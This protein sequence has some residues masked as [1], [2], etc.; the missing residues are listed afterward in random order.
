MMVL[1][2]E[3]TVN[4]QVATA[5]LLAEK[6]L[7]PWLPQDEFR[8]P[9]EEMLVKGENPLVFPYTERRMKVVGDGRPD[10]L[11]IDIDVA[12]LLPI[13]QTLQEAGWGYLAAVTGVDLGAE[14]GE[15][16][17]LYHFC[18]GAAVLALCVKVAR[19]TAVVPSICGIIPSASFFERELREMLGVEITDTPNT[20]KLFLPDEWPEGLFPLRK[21]FDPAHINPPAN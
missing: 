3:T 17:I 7:E 8:Q 13:I 5:L 16:E 14:S 12:D 18:E 15:M 20:D 2:P 21:D 4:Q 19:E 9:D 6:L 11:G 10:V 1:E